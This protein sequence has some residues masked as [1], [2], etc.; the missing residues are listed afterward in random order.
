MICGEWFEKR[1]S[2]SESFC[3]PAFNGSQMVPRPISLPAP[4]RCSDVVRL[5]DHVNMRST[6]VHFCSDQSQPTNEGLG[7]RRGD[8]VRPA[9]NI[10]MLWA[11]QSGS[12]RRYSAA[13]LSFQ[14]ALVRLWLAQLSQCEP[15]PVFD[16]NHP[17][18]LRAI[19][20]TTDGAHR[21]DFWST[22]AGRTSTLTSST[23]WNQHRY[24]Q[25][26]SDS[27]RDTQG[28]TVGNFE[29][30]HKIRTRCSSARDVAGIHSTDS[31]LHRNG[32][33]S[34]RGR[35]LGIR[36][37]SAHSAPPV[38]SRMILTVFPA[39]CKLAAASQSLGICASQYG[40]STDRKFHPNR[41]AMRIDI[42]KSIRSGNFVACVL[43]PP[44]FANQ[45]SVHG[46]SE[47]SSVGSQRGAGRAGR[48]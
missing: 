48:L 41:R 2:H 47:K 26:I 38:Q 31:G 44:V 18:L 6:G 37:G 14:S 3:Q 29:E 8:T 16:F 43:P 42:I 28:R 24:E 10:S 22:P 36:Y 20:A 11:N 13:G 40:N 32:R 45:D 9:A 1:H 30:S 25:S 21:V 15:R 33:T 23:Q 27:N 5:I 34:S 46:R 7:L 19:N 17:N 35:S 12:E 4:R 39:A